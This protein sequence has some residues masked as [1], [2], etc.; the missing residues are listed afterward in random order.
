MAGEN[1]TKISVNFSQSE[2]MFSASQSNMSKQMSSEPVQDV[3]PEQESQSV[4][5]SKGH[6]VDDSDMILFNALN[7]EL[8]RYNSELAAKE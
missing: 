8:G 7:E 3:I 6:K 1:Q 5:K 2:Q 4:D